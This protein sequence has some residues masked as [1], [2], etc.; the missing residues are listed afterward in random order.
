MSPTALLREIEANKSKIDQFRPL[1]LSLVQQIRAYWRVGLTYSSNAIEG[2]TLTETET[3]V[4]IE[5]GLTIGGKSLR[6]TFEVVGHSDAMTFLY[7]FVDKK[8]KTSEET[9]KKLHSCFYRLIDE[10]NAGSYRKTAIFI[11]GTDYIPPKW[12]ELETLMKK[13]VAPLLISTEPIPIIAAK[14]HTLIANMHPFIDGNGR[15][16]RLM[17]NLLL[18][19]HGYPITVVPPIY[20]VKY[21]QLCNQANKGNDS[22]FLT[23]IQ[24]LVLQ[25]QTDYLRLL[26][27]SR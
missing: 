20:R 12:E 27:A 5:D 17:M 21:I 19:Q 2:N 23:F 25:A 15:T 9:V 18:L 26:E 11:S 3:K 22:G 1:S 6:E 14:W 4:L 16:A 24:E 13:G 10:A 7:D 8:E